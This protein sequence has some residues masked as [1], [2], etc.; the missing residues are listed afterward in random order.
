[1]AETMFFPQF[2][3]GGG[4]WRRNLTSRMA[5]CCV[6]HGYGYGYGYGYLADAFVQ[7]EQLR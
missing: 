5:L 6:E 4:L 7:S 2:Q 1:M 3:Y